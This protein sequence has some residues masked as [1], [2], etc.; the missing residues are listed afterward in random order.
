M[1]V[2]RHIVS[3]LLSQKG[4]KGVLLLALL[5]LRIRLIRLFALLHM[6]T[7]LI[8]MHLSI[9]PVTHAVSYAY[10]H[11]YS[12]TLRR[13]HTQ[14]IHAHVRLTV[15][16]ARIGV[17]D[18]PMLMR[19]PVSVLRGIVLARRQSALGQRGVNHAHTQILVPFP[20]HSA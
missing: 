7:M 19:V 8:R 15:N 12:V 10:P 3:H 5:A 13:V 20:F 1:Y 17:L 2:A 16:G 4:R 6:P 18:M 11:T 14:S 9:L